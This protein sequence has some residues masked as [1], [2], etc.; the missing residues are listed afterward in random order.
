MAMELVVMDVDRVSRLFKA[1]QMETVLLEILEHRR[2]GAVS[3]DANRVG[4]IAGDV[5]L[6]FRRAGA[7]DFFE[8]AAT[9]CPGDPRKIDVTPHGST[10]EQQLP[11]LGKFAGRFV[12]LVLKQVWYSPLRNSAVDVK[13]VRISRIH[14][15]KPLP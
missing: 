2:Q 15:L 5:A 9:G 14:A 10:N 8:P 3:Y 6:D 11:R 4:P 13:L 1:Y 12:A 7:Y